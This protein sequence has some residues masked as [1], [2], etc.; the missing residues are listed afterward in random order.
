[1]HEGLGGRH[2]G[3]G[4]EDDRRVAFLARAV[5]E[6]DRRAGRD[7]RPVF[8]GDQ[9]AD[10][11]GA[12]DR[13]GTAAA[14]FCRGRFFEQRGLADRQAAGAQPAVAI[15]VEHD[16]LQRRRNAAVGRL[17]VGVAGEV[18][19]RERLARQLPRREAAVGG[20]HQVADLDQ[21]GVG[22]SREQDAGDNHP[23][24]QKPLQISSDNQASAPIKPAGRIGP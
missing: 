11:P 21:R 8:A 19:R 22:P 20:Q 14:G 23:D 12:D 17:E 15:E 16:L 9:G 2:R 3:A 6:R 10:V 4:V 1:M 18:D 7:R 5:E 24:S 13:V